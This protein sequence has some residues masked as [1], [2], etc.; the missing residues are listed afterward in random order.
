AAARE[1]SARP[2]RIGNIPPTIVVEVG[3]AVAGGDVGQRIRRDE[4]ADAATDGE[5]AVDGQAVAD[6]TTAD[7]GPV[8]VDEAA[9]HDAIPLA[10][11]APGERDEAAVG[12]LA[13]DLG[14]AIRVA[15]AVL[16]IGPAVAN[17]AAEVHAGPS[18]GG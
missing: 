6:A 15:I 14:I 12:I 2:V 5:R 13:V 10:V 16:G 7:V 18:G 3:A 17:A 8:E 11:I 4:S 1:H 9:D